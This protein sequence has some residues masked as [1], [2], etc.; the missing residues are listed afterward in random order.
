MTF[1][2]FL[3]TS[4]CWDAMNYYWRTLGLTMTCT[5][6]THGAGGA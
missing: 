2:R 6:N 1:R 4:V 5:V 3:R